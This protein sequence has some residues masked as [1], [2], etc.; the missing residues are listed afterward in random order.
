VHLQK[1]KTSLLN[2]YIRVSQVK[3]EVQKDKSTAL[4]LPPGTYLKCT[5]GYNAGQV[6]KLLNDYTITMDVKVDALPN[7]RYARD[8][9]LFCCPPFLRYSLAVVVISSDAIYFP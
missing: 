1:K 4:V 8:F 9:L 2:A 6:P 5:L 7:D 3:L